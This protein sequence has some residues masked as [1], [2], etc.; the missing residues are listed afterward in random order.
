MEIQIFPDGQ[1]VPTLELFEAV[2]KGVLELG[3]SL[4]AYESG[5]VP[6]AALGYGVPYF[7]ENHN[8]LRNFYYKL[9]FI[10]ILRGEFAKYGVYFLGPTMSHHVTFLTKKPVRKAD[11][12]K[13]LKL[14]ATGL[15]ADIV[16]KAGASAVFLPGPEIY[17]SLE[18]G[19][20]DGT[21]WGAEGAMYSLGYHEVTKYILAP[22]P[23]K[24]AAL[25][26][27]VNQAK[28]N[29]LPDDLKAILEMGL[30]IFSVNDGD[31]NEYNDYLHRAKM[32]KEKNLEV[33]Y[34]PPEEEAKM[35]K[36][37][38]EV[39]DLYA[40]KDAVYAKGAAIMKDYLKLMGRIN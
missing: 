15:I 6:V 25:E 35:R 37:A 14:R 7:M 30:Q 31:I 1:V 40:A 39:L 28:W 12:F 24:A 16:A 32:I 20:I 36:F 11:D 33:T 2:G 10:D 9:G 4:P 17:P 8:E 13:G 21:H 19:V 29:A 22:H 23:Q 26:V 18:K 34:F 27:F 5:K 3:H 38:V